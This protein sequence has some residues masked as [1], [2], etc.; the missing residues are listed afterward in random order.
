MLKPGLPMKAHSHIL[1]KMLKVKAKSIVNLTIL[2]ESR[3]GDD[4]SNL[5]AFVGHLPRIETH[6]FSDRYKGGGTNFLPL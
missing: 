3:A 4:T 5:A 1:L 6:G 2:D